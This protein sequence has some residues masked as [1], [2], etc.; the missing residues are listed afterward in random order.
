MAAT[1]RFPRRMLTLAVTTAGAAALAA[2]FTGTANATTTVELHHSGDHTAHDHGAG[3]PCSPPK[4][5]R[6]TS[7]PAPLLAAV[8]DTAL[9]TPAPTTSAR[10]AAPA[11]TPALAGPAAAEQPAGAGMTPTAAGPASSPSPAHA[12]SGAA[13]SAAGANPA[14]KAPGTRQPAGPTTTPINSGSTVTPIR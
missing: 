1:T 12:P 7:S 10:S 2:S 4:G 11:A 13:P 5:A 14:A 9:S 8:L 3:H 6:N